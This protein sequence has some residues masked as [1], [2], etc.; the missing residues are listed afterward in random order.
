MRKTALI[1]PYFK[2]NSFKKLFKDRKTVLVGGCFD[3]IH[4][5]HIDYLSKSASLGD[6]FIV[7][8]NSDSSVKKI[9]GPGRPINDEKTRIY[10]LSSFFFTDAVVLFDD[11][12]PYELICKIIPDIL[13]KGGDYGEDEIVGGDVVKKTGGKVVI[14]PYIEGYSTSTIIDKIR[15]KS[16]G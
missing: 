13:V 4:A 10:V 1:I 15:G 12:T 9:K 2:I 3:L 8:V 7:A 5:G 14:L 11:E 16:S 6:K